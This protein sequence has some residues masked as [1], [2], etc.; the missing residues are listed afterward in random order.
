MKRLCQFGI[1]IC[2][3]AYFQ[4]DFVRESPKI[5]SAWHN[6]SQ[7]NDVLVKRLMYLCLFRLI[8]IQICVNGQESQRVR[9]AQRTKAVLCGLNLAE[10]MEICIYSLSAEGLISRASQAF[11][12]PSVSTNADTSLPDESVSDTATPRE[13]VVQTFYTN[14]SVTVRSSRRVSA[15]SRIPVRS[16][17]SWSDPLCLYFTFLFTVRILLGS[18]SVLLSRVSEFGGSYYF[19]CFVFSLWFWFFSCYFSCTTILTSL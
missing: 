11:Y 6:W 1:G 7:H 4:P 13:V 14:S 5:M 16:N 3:A 9:S 15:A 12:S 19:V 2:L 10:E 18:D 8:S 17:T